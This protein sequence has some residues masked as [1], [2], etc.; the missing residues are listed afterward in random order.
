VAA[1][2]EQVILMNEWQKK[3]IADLVIKKLGGKIQGQENCYS[4]ICF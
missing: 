4:W 3:R 2:W 1:Y